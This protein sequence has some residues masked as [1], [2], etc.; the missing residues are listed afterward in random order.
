LYNFIKLFFFVF[1]FIINRA[2]GDVDLALDTKTN[3]KIAIKRMLWSKQ[4]RKELI[5][6]EILVMKNCRFRSIVNFLDCYLRP[7][8]LWSMEFFFPL[9]KLEYKSSIIYLVVMEYMNGGQLT[10][11]VEQTVLDEGQMAAVTK[12]CLE[13]LQFLHSKNIIHRDVKSDNVLVGFDGSG[14][15]N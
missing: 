12:E 14:K 4:P 6:S 15:S 10:Q 9:Y 11:I 7:G 1:L 3:I 2:A 5:V 8:E 13:A